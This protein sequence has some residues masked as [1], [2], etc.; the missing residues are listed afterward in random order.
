LTIQAKDG[1]I[2]KVNDVYFDDDAWIVRYLIDKT[3]FWLFGQQVLISPASVQTIDMEKQQIRVDLTR[4]QVASNPKVDKEKPLT[5]D[6]EKYLDT[7][8]LVVGNVGAGGT[9]TMQSESDAVLFDRD[10]I[11]RTRKIVQDEETDGPNIISTDDVLRYQISTSDGDLGVVSDFIL[12]VNSWEIRYL[13]I[14]IDEDQEK[15]VLIDPEWI[16]WISWRKRRIS[17]SMKREK[18]KACPNF[19]LSLPL[20]REYEDLLYDHYECKKYWE[21]NDADS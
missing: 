21:R 13:V 2:G 17:V 10:L 8:D 12:D 6:A 3:G 11:E 7:G 14:E 16:D 19:D 5:R 20:Q 18:I 15:K 4:D 1:E 9:G